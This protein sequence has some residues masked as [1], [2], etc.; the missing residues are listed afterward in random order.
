MR[1]R[2]AVLIVN[3]AISAWQTDKA[4]RLG[5]ALAYYAAFSLGPLLLLTIAAAGTIFGED[6]AQGRL[7]TQVRGLMGEQGGAALQAIIAS[8]K[9]HESGTIATIIGSVML[10]FA[11]AGLFGALQDA[12]NTVWE[13]QPKA[14][15]GVRGIVRDRF[16]SF[17]M[18]LGATFLL[19]VSLVISATLAAMSH[20]FGDWETIG[21]TRQALHSITAFGVITLLFAMIFKYLPDAK[22]AWRDVWFGA[23][24]TSL[25]FAIGKLGIGLYLGHSAIASAY[26]AAGSLA[27]LLIWLYY[28][29]QIFLFGAELT[30]AHATWSGR[31]IVP[32]AN[33]ER[34]TIEARTQQGMPGSH[35]PVLRGSG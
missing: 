12:L 15:R 29:A 30:K 7:I 5:A 11:A 33:A 31:G 1:P 4:S 32:S 27:V 6:A 26:G 2:D 10:L 13:V 21:A 34:I 14:D 22:V 19:F 17:V 18:V 23:A 16:L 28:S 25:L 24:V 9:T 3:E 35:G 20:R 8:A